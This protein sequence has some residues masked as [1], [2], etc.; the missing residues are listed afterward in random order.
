M[1]MPVVTS[2]YRAP[3]GLRSGHLQTVLR[4]A[5]PPRHPGP[6]RRERL[7]LDDGDFLDLDW[8]EGRDPTRVAVICHGLEGSSR[9]VYVLEAASA[10]LEAGW[11]VLAWNYR[12]CSGEPNRLLRSYHS[13]GTDDLECVIQ[14][15]RRSWKPASL[16]LVGFSLGGNLV[17]KHAGERAGDCDVSAVVAVSAPI[18]LAASA[19]LLDEAPENRVYLWRFLR[20]LA[21]KVRAKSARFPGRIDPRAW[22]KIRT[23]RELDE[24][25]TAPMHGFAGAEDYWERC[26]ARAGLG[27]IRIPTLLVS[28]RNDPLLCSASHPLEIARSSESFHFEFPATGGHVAFMGR[29]GWLGRRIVEFLSQ[30]E[31]L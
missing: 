14:H 9:A 21:G 16:G 6:P 25:Y 5:A 11:S 31:N 24:F 17:L 8:W 19:R 20:T 22:R 29:R 10:L 23:I 27:E 12:G 26:S 28:A 1:R 15:A 13:G 2:S 18:D 3:I 30:G 4:A 7:E